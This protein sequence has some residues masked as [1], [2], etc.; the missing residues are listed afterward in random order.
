MEFLVGFEVNIPAGTEASKIRDLQ[1]AEASAAARLSDDGH[2][3]RLWRPHA[4]PGGAGALGL[5]RADDEAQLDR[6][7]ADLPL[8]DWLRVT[9]TPLEPHSNDPAA[10]G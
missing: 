7:L 8:H 6:L 9:V 5:Y 1:H 3:V 4:T 2:L 10:R